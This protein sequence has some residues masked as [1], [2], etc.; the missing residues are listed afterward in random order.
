M[1]GGGGGFGLRASFATKQSRGP[2][3]FWEGGASVATGSHSHP[4][5]FVTNKTQLPRL[6]RRGHKTTSPW[7]EDQRTYVIF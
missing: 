7:E 1:W 2:R 4:I 6:E 3:A 5:L